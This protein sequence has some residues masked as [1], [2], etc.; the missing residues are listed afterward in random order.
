[1]DYKKILKH[2]PKIIFISFFIGLSFFLFRSS[3]EELI[4]LIGIRS[5]YIVIFFLAFLGG[6]TTFT[7]IPCHPILAVFAAGSPHPILLGF[8]T[9]LG[10]MLGDPL[11]IMSATTEAPSSQKK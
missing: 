7:G 2:S 5:S 9:S 10:V 6:L 1:M 3:P 11:L 8:A 4:S